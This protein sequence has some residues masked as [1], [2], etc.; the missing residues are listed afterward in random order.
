MAIQEINDTICAISTPPGS[1]GIA[2]V[3]ISGPQ[4]IKIADS[5]WRGKSL[6]NAATHSAHFGTV[7][8]ADG[9]ELDEGVATVFRGPRSFTGEDTVEIS[10]HGS[11]W[12]QRQVVNALIDK[13]A[14]SAGPGEFTRRA[15]ASGRL[16]L[17]QAEAVADL[18]ASSSRAAA[19]VALSQMR[20]GVSSRLDTLRTKLIELAALLELELDFSEED[21]E[22][23][24]RDKLVEATSNI[25]QELRRLLSTFRSGAAIKDGIPVAIAG[26]T[27]AGKS[28]LLNALL[29]EERA[30]VSDIHGTT[31]DTI[32]DTIEIGDYLFR[33]ID[34]AGIRRTDDKIER[35]GIERSMRALEHARIVLHVIDASAPKAIELGS[36]AEDATIITIMNKCDVADAGASEGVRI[37]AL[38][39][40]GIDMV[41]NSLVQAAER[42]SGNTG[43][44]AVMITNVR[45]AEAL[46][47]A[48]TS[49]EALLDG[50][51]T[52]IPADLLAQDLRETLHHLSTITGE[53]TTNDILINIF[54]NFCIGK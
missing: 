47:S 51:R 36:V 38:T 4:A 54:E 6:E 25:L 42:E 20:G 14:R 30:I 45:H 23:A 13:G 48:A 10:V 11:K 1:G 41:R 37:S 29:G 28:S 7:V 32:E 53:I 3:R 31:R 33:F 39:G 22:F 19:R 52:T 26:A 2:V 27:N 35:L 5:L 50:L 17:V 34:T 21:V 46:K 40:E 24:S 9:S 15:F 8:D 44:D 18:I 43:E 12:I 16:D 49:A